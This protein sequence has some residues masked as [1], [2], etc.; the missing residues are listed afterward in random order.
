MSIGGGAAITLV[1]NT[2]RP[3]TIA[4]I[5]V[6]W[7]TTHVSDPYQRVEMMPSL[8]PV[9]LASSSVSLTLTLP[10]VGCRV[11]ETSPHPHSLA[12]VPVHRV[13]FWKKFYARPGTTRPPY[14]NRR[15]HR[16]LY[17]FD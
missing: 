10:A 9:V 4:E 17:N 1:P 11:R 16:K 13:T 8:P 2:A 7:V 12:V 14:E 15:L 5:D 6:T 3:Q